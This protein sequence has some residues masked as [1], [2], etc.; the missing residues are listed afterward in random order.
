MS[1]LVDLQ[2]DLQRSLL[3]Q[4]PT[5]ALEWISSGGRGTPTRQLG[6]YEHA[7]RARLKEVL[8]KDF[9]ALA[10]VLG[11][12][13][14]D[15]LSDDYI[16][17]FPSD[18]FTLR[19]YG[20][21]FPAFLH[22]WHDL[23]QRTGLAE[24]AEFEWLL[25]EA[26]DAAEAPLVGEQDLIGIAAENWPALRFTFHPSVQRCDHH[27]NS[28]KLWQTYKQDKPL[29]RLR[30]LNAALPWLIWRAS[31]TTRFVSLSE[32]EQVA[33]DAVHTGKNFAEVCEALSEVTDQENLP[34]Y[35]ASLL[36]DWINKGLISDVFIN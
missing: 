17:R 21:R 22:Q 8:G 23:P 27:W 29:P 3:E 16:A 34:L 13:Q 7:Y 30:R 25:I 18:S 35:A 14:F 4:T 33:L 5:P 6:I 32:S 11:E 36:K 10:A 31:L 26:F 15:W 12:R 1:R 9:E 28:V 2:R 24:L 19:H 20:R